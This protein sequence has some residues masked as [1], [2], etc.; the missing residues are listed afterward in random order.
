MWVQRYMS[1]INLF[2]K[3]THRLVRKWQAMVGVVTIGPRAIILNQ[4]NQVLLVKHTYQ[5]H[6]YL[7]GGGLKKG[8]SAKAA[9]LRELKEEVGLTVLVEP[10]LFCIYHHTY[11]GVN[12]YPIIYIVK[13]FHITPNVSSPEIERVNW[14][15]YD[16][17]PDK[18]SPGTKR[19]LDEYFTNL[20]PAERW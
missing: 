10:H 13:N 1:L 15:S 12:D 8:E 11:L 6:W 20:A 17:L 19:R 18:I 5:S 14:F 9:L 16:N 7:P 4:D 3:V 2:H